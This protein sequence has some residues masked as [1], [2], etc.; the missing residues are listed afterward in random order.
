MK[1]FLQGRH[2]RRTPLE[3]RGQAIFVC[4]KMTVVADEVF[5]LTLTPTTRT[6]ELSGVPGSKEV[7][8]RLSTSS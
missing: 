6:E 5:T 1:Y 2:T 3:G 8:P 4:R 7:L